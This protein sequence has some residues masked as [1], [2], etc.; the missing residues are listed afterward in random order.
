MAL[1]PY[2]FEWGWG[3]NI[4]K[5]V[6]KMVRGYA[7]HFCSGSDSLGDLRI[8]WVDIAGYFKIRKEKLRAWQGSPNLRADIRLTPLRNEIAD[9]VIADPPY[10]RPGKDHLTFKNLLKNEMLRVLR[11]GGYFIYYADQIPYMRSLTLREIYVKRNL[12]RPFYRILSL[13]EKIQG[14]L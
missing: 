14:S 6:K 5:L 3:G 13:S 12:G 9:T 7:I 11:P 1:Q 2:R 8:D 4:H 10:K